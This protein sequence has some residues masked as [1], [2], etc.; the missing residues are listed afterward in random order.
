VDNNPLAAEKNRRIIR[1]GW[2]IAALGYS[3]E[4][5]AI[6]GYIFPVLYSE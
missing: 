2:R 3:Y 5:R 1:I 4:Q 6:S